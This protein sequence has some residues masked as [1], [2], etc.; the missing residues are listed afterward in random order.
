MDSANIVARLNL[1]NMAYPPELK[2]EV[3]SRAREEGRQ[4]EAAA[5]LRRLLSLR[6]KTIPGWVEDLLKNAEKVDLEK[7]TDRILDAKT[8]EEV[9]SGFHDNSR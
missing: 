5:T 9:F 6:F 4:E 3:Y 8:V 2:L 1:P 7:W